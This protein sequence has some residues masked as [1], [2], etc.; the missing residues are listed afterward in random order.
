[1][2]TSNTLAVGWRQEKVVPL[3]LSFPLPCSVYCQFLV[4]YCD[5]VL[6]GNRI[7]S[8]EQN[9]MEFS[10][11]WFLPS[12][13]AVVLF[14]KKRFYDND[15]TCTMMMMMMM[16]MMI[17]IKANADGVHDGRAM[18]IGLLYSSHECVCRYPDP[19][20]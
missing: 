8:G 14:L 6:A 10:L 20:V 12:L 11:W 2:S 1:M 19:S 16:M 3:S 5:K 4:L 9:L 15:T 17:V 18:F 7:S 13:V